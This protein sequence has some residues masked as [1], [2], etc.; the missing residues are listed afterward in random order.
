MYRWR[1][2]IVVSI[3]PLVAGCATVDPNYE[4]PIVNVSAIRALPAEGIAPRFE[5]GLHI[6]NPNRHALK[7][8]G[9]AYHLQI[10][11]Y[12]ILTGVA[13]KL[14]TI[15]GY[16]EETV[17]L[18]ASTNLLSSIRF[19]SDLMNTNRDMITYNLEAKL[20]L[21]GF[22]PTLRVVESGEINLSAKTK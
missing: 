6:I 11:G 17:T 10:E 19:L 20:D 8:E 15:E 18:I 21:G 1:W 2:I 4:T 13:N 9:V 5:I 14:P 12:K 22:Q 7:L 16:G 3:L